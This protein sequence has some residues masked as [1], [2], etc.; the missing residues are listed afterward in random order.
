MGGT[1]SLHIGACPNCSI[2]GAARAPLYMMSTPNWYMM[3]SMETRICSNSLNDVSV[4]THGLCT[5]ATTWP[6]MRSHG[7]AGPWS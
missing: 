7:G 3:G 5:P 6:A 1:P 4:V 2:K